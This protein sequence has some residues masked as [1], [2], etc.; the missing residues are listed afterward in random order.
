ME[1]WDYSGLPPVERYNAV[2]DL[3]NELLAALKTVRGHLTD[4][5]IDTD[6]VVRQYA[7]AI[8]VIHDAI[9]KAEG[10]PQPAAVA[11][12]IQQGLRRWVQSNKY[13]RAED[14]KA[15]SK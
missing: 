6:G 3:A 14:A 5:F 13:G 1:H 8:I 2:V 12:D 10:K 15:E 4:P 9:T 7:K 11:T